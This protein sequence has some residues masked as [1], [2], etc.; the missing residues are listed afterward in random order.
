MVPTRSFMYFIAFVVLIGM[1]KLHA[2]GFFKEGASD[3]LKLNITTTCQEQLDIIQSIR[4][5]YPKVISGCPTNDWNNRSI[6]AQ[7]VRFAA[8]YC[9]HL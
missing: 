6:Q 3:S 7:K 2:V 9:E 8:N 5:S 1:G 4:R